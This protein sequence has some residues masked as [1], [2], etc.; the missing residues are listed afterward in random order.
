MI[1]LKHTLIELIEFDDGGSFGISETF[2][3]KS[4][5]ISLEANESEYAEGWG[6]DK[7]DSVCAPLAITNSS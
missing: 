7:V 4:K 1:N 2:S 6:L 5:I 3:G